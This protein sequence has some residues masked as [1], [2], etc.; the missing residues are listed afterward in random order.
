M[1]IFDQVEATALATHYAV[2][3]DTADYTPAG[4]TAV[5]ITLIVDA[6]MQG[7]RISQGST[8]KH[9]VLTCRVRK[10]EIPTPGTG[11]V[12]TFNNVAYQ[13]TF[14][15]LSSRDT[16]EWTIEAVSVGI[17]RRGGTTVLPR[18]G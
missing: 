5:E 8:E 16:N 9:S 14:N 18:M 1:S 3:G 7:E 11:D 10:S 13:I 6:L 2:N 4:G 15:P 17:V 12:I